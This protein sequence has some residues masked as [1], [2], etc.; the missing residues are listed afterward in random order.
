MQTPARVLSVPTPCAFIL[1]NRH[2][3]CSSLSSG[4]PRASHQET[5]RSIAA[6]W[7]LCH[8]PPVADITNRSWNS[9]TL[10]PDWSHFFTQWSTSSVAT[11]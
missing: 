4:G 3:P 1:F 9:L 6:M 5:F 7:P 2:V 8:G 10:N 11:N